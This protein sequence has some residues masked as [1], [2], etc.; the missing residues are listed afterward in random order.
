M[1]IAVESTS[2]GLA[3]QTFRAKA[4]GT[5]TVPLPK[6][7]R[8]AHTLTVTATSGSGATMISD[9]LTR[10]FTVRESRL[11]RT[12]TA[13]VDGAGGK[14]IPGGAGLTTLVV[15][16]ASAGR[17][18]PMLLGVAGGDGARLE[19]A[20]GAA[21]A[22]ALLSRHYGGSEGAPPAGDFDGTAYQVPGG[23]I[24]PVPYGS[25]ELRLTALVAIVAPERFHAG[26]LR[27]YLDS[28]LANPKST[29]ER[30]VYA[31]AGLAGLGAPVLPQLQAAAADPKLTIRE[32]LMTG[33]GAA[34]IGDAGTARA[35]AASLWASHGEETA[36]QAR[37]RVGEDADDVTD[38]TA[39]MAVLAA[40]I[41]DA[42][43][44]ALW[45][46][47]E[48]NP[49]ATGPY[50]LFGVAFVEH[51]IDR[52][53]VEPASFAYVLDGQRT[54][55][56][57]DTGDSFQLAL[58][59]PQ[60]SA[61]RIEPIGGSIV[62]TSTWREPVAASSIKRDPTISIT[63]SRTPADIRTSDLVRVD[64][65][66]T[67]DAKAPTGCL[68]VT[69]LVPS[70]LI[71]MGPMTRWYYGDEDSR[72]AGGV[73]SP[74]SV[75][76]QRVTFCAEPTKKHRTV[77]LRYYARV[78]SPGRYVWE[79]AI[80]ELPTDAARAAMTKVTAIRIR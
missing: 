68:L 21:M 58:T 10:S 76:G 60:R 7:T 55:I 42:R 27:T 1:R 54:V 23:G 65:R 53:P 17:Y 11:E 30:R 61:L 51:L 78:I 12:R 71:P 39:L 37:L 13:L 44:P 19:R 28:V 20:L 18:L 8:G 56:E 33:L 70:G 9:T 4:F 59:A 16:D 22:S 14:P 29:R 25:A 79:P 2:L 62:V 52:L 63:R 46:Y 48:A 64:L 32:S 72:P 47:V 36:G 77:L 67:V 75:V 41:G 40:A 69:E 5:V 49:S 3:K 43:A 73:A 74:V 15:A 24:A 26:S 45:A 6:L 66:V 80:V 50:E 34:A 38:A 31:L 35:I 57:L